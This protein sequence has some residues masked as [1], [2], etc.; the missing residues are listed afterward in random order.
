MFTGEP[1][2][3]GEVALERLLRGLRV[4]L[5][6]S[7]PYHP[8][9]CPPESQTARTRHSRPL[10]VIIT[11]DGQLLRDPNRDYE[12]PGVKKGPQHPKKRE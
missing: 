11:R 1:R 10:P 9:T 6:H 3:H 8:Q 7:R 12:P 4:T 5:D 2:G